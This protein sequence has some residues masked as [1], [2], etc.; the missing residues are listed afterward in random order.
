MQNVFNKR[1]EEIDEFNTIL[2]E[3]NFRNKKED[4]NSNNINSI[5]DDLMVK[6]RSCGRGIFKDEFIST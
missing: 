3:L 2:E 5:P 6:C 1:K 4:S